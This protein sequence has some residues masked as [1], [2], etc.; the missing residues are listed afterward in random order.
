MAEYD[1]GFDTGSSQ[2]DHAGPGRR[3]P[4]LLLLLFG[5]VALA[6]SGWALLGP[7]SLDVLASFDGGWVLV[8]AAVVIGAVLVFLPNR[9]SK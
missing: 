1:T 9:R 7:F 2:K 6:V 5:L 4:S 3:G 8:G